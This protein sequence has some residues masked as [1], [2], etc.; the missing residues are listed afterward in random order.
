M[1]P[2]YWRVFNQSLKLNIS[3]SLPVFALA[4]LL[5]FR[6]HVRGATAVYVNGYYPPWMYVL[7]CSDAAHTS[8]CHFSGFSACGQTTAAPRLWLLSVFQGSKI[9]WD[10]SVCWKGIFYMWKLCK[11]ERSTGSSGSP[12]HNCWNFMAGR[13]K[14]AHQ[15]LPVL[16]GTFPGEAGTTFSSS[17]VSGA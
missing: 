5:S 17:S 14:C 7:A 1:L 15:H 16:S 9:I 10:G 11:K 4:H 3:H 13:E 6:V 2:A 8:S 12:Q